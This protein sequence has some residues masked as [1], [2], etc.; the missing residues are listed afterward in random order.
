MDWSDDGIVLTARKHGESASIV[1]LMTAEHGRHAGLVRG[2]AGRRARGIYQPGNIVRATWRARLEEHL[3]TFTCELLQARAA[4][5]LDDPLRLAGL[6]AA[7]TI[8][9]A[10]LP[11]REA[12][13][14]MY[15]RLNRLLDG[16]ADDDWLAAFVHWENDL[17][18]RLGFGLDFSECVS[19]GSTDELIYV[20]PKSGRAVSA[21][22]GAPYKDRLLRLPD[23]LRLG[24]AAAAVPPEEVLDGLAVTGYFLEHHVFALNGKK[25]PP[26]RIRFVDR[27]RQLATISGVTP[28]K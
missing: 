21:G 14:E 23:F 3:G 5:A 9:E 24:E 20:S 16:M 25:T 4:D 11:E 7:C 28:A 26:A 15:E 1:T 18:V 19:T 8:T 6:S 10:A 2:G 27:I 12:Y 22:A 13:A 17:L